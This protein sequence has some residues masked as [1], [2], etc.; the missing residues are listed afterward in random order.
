MTTKPMSNKRR[1]ATTMTD[2]P[3]PPR[4]D[5]A[6][7]DDRPA[8]PTRRTLLIG[9]G[10]ASGASLLPGRGQAAPA[11]SGDA[12]PGAPSETA[13]AREAKQF[14]G[15]HQAGVLTPQPAA[16]L[17]AAFDVVAESR[18]ELAGLFRTLTERIRFLTQGG[19]VPVID[20]K[21]P[22]PDSGLM[23]P[24][25]V[26]DDLTMTV[27][28]GASLFDDRFG[29]AAA[30]PR[31]L[32]AM[33]QFPND[34]LDESLCHGDLL[35]QICSNT[36]ETN[37]HALR[38]LVK[39][40]PGLVA[41]RWTLDG[42]LPPRTANLSG[43][44][45]PG[46]GTPR[47]MLGFKD[48]TANLDT[49]DAALMN[50]IVW[51]QPG[52]GEPAWATGGSYQVVRMIRNLVERWDR[53]PLQ[54]QETIIGRNKATGAPLGMAAEHDVPNYAADPHGTRMPMN[55]HIRLAN[56]RSHTTQA[57]LILRRGYNYSRGMTHA[58]QLDMGLLFV[59][60]QADLKA[61][62]LTVQQ[63]LNG[64]PLEEYV[65]PFGGGYFFALPG[66]DRPGRYL[67]QGLLE[68]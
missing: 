47:N 48:G 60:F 15:R 17:L 49:Q 46:K 45:T 63:R 13:H 62:F 26:P 11:P 39:N 35:V 51:V 24:Q 40:L 1:D 31:H 8:S 64:E 2:H 65:K 59:C 19:T 6:A 42:F 18:D 55:A 52:A 50:R 28:V 25:V 16:A 20:A 10:A 27:A 34:A 5:A 53:T 56:P 23:G 30:K 41:L 22:P 58:G 29:L 57:N 33:S 43:K 36:A 54:E 38:D 68:A 66:V 32:V 21:L 14:Y 44:G 4:P 3:T 7:A 67:G 61:G 37:I 9:L 12:P